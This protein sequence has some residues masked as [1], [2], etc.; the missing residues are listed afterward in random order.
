MLA[1]E[2]VLKQVRRRDGDLSY[3]FVMRGYCGD[4]A[5]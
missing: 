5:K 1:V 4:R 3:P 2:Q